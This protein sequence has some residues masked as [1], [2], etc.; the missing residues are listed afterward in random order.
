MCLQLKY[1]CI[2]LT[3]SYASR[4]FLLFE[5]GTL[6][7]EITLLDFLSKGQ[8]WK[9]IIC[10]WRSKFCTVSVYPL[11]KGRCH[12]GRLIGSYKSYS[13]LFKLCTLLLSFQIFIEAK[14][15]Y[16]T[17]GSLNN[18]GFYSPIPLSTFH[19]SFSTLQIT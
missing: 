16:A 13:P 8:F 19:S 14:M 11:F 6:W 5:I 17:K 4:C 7:R 12:P 10:S 2:H 1:T 9:R 3:W 15:H 18:F